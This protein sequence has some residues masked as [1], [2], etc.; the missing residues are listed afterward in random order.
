[1]ILVPTVLVLAGWFLWIVAGRL[2]GDVAYSIGLWQG[3]AK[4]RDV[5]ALL[6]TTGVRYPSAW[7]RPG[8]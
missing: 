4:Q 2:L 5:R 1:M 8:R 7:P 6:S 3:C